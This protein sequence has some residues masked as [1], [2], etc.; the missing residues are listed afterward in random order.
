MKN[1]GEKSEFR[2]N[3]TGELV[4]RF[5]VIKEHMGVNNDQSVLA[6]LIREA[7]DKLQELRYRKV[8]IQSDKYELIEK[9]AAAQGKGVDVY[10]WE[11]VDA[12]IKKSKEGVKHAN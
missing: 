9:E 1:K 4:E 10:V 11:L 6:L 2:V 5:L 7:Y 12:E 8:F 3:L